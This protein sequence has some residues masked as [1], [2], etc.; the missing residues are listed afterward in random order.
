MGEIGKMIMKTLELEGFSLREVTMGVG[1]RKKEIGEIEI[2]KGVKL[3]EEYRNFI[4]KYGYWFLGFEVYGL[5]G[6]GYD[7]LESLTEARDEMSMGLPEGNLLIENADEY[8]YVLNLESGKIFTWERGTDKLE[9]EYEGF[10]DYFKDRL[11]SILD[12]Y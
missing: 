2:K 12:D 7:E 11:Q 1:D 9:Y 4:S 3:P 5:V 6:E 10:N 8:M